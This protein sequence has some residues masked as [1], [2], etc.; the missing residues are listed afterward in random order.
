M[1]A[2]GRLRTDGRRTP[3]ADEHFASRLCTLDVRLDLLGRSPL[4][5]GLPPPDVMT[6]S[7]LFRERSYDEG[8]A[9]YR[10]GEPAQRLYVV[11]TGK[12]KLER[13][14]A[15]GHS[16][17]LDI[18]TS[19]EFFGSLSMLGEATYRE[20]AVAQTACCVLAVAA[21]GFL[22]ILHRYPPVALAA[23]ELV[24]ARLRAAHE[25]MEHQS[26]QSAEG[27]IAALLLK[28]GEKLGEA[29]QDALLIQMPLS[30][31]DLA[32]MAGTSVETASRIMSRF[33]K[34]GLVHSGRRWVAITDGVRLANIAEDRQV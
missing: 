14:T 11:A 33:R 20:S 21:D 24:A 23:L 13:T 27:R 19:G 22:A 5:V 2:D 15:S 30:R 9:I 7:R 25:S 12:V 17:L 31:Q 34:D 4:F 18:L 26:V 1:S 32:D 8:Q 10:A 6:V 28:L 3:L 16:V 29:N